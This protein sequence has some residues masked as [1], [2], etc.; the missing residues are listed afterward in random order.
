MV[1]AKLRLAPCAFDVA[2]DF[3]TTHHRHL[4]GPIGHLWST[5]AVLGSDVVGV[6]IVGRPVA[7]ILDDGWTVEVVRCT[8]TGERNVCSLLY[9]AVW[10]AAKARGYRAAT[11][12]T[13]TEETGASLR[14]ANWEPETDIRPARGGWHRPARP[15][16]NTSN[17]SRVRWWA[18]GSDHGPHA[19]IDWPGADPEPSLLDLLETAP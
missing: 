5:A 16:A 2:R 11:T 15:R 4:D 6:V 18:P 1:E 12:M 3:T 13:M 10:R 14:A 8:T 17:P 19:E 9:S 7:R